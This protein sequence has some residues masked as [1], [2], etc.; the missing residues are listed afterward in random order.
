[1]IDNHRRFWFQ[2][3][4]RNDGSTRPALVVVTDQRF[5]GE[6]EVHWLTWE[7]L[8]RLR[9]EA[10]ALMRGLTEGEMDA[11][12]AVSNMSGD[13]AGIELGRS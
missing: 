9:N 4:N 8:R 13:P 7:E 10:N 12:D 1:M 2:M 11:E 6:A 3:R 5:E